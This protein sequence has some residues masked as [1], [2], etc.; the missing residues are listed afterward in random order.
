MLSAIA[1]FCP[2]ISRKAI[3]DDS[4][5]LKKVWH[6]IRLHYN[7]QTSGANFLDF[8]NSN[9]EPDEKPEDLYKRMSA[10]ISDNLLK[11]QLITQKFMIKMMKKRS[12]MKMKVYPHPLKIWLSWY[13]F[14]NFIPA[15][16]K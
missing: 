7:I 5:S 1:S 4:R 9:L 3:V 13:G 16:L 6:T 10:F 12:E 8:I 11:I 15:Y 2:V 14:K